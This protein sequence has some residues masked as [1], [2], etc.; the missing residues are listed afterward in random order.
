MVLGGNKINVVE[1][2]GP[3]GTTSIDD[4]TKSMFLWQFISVI[5]AYGFS[6]I[7]GPNDCYSSMSP[8][9]FGMSHCPNTG[10]SFL[11]ASASVQMVL[12][13]RRNGRCD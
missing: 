13:W 1:A 6:W 2:Y 11:A 12:C 9:D 7:G 10:F 4:A 3:G 5:V 8:V